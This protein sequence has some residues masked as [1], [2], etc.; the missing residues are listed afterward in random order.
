MKTK[1]IRNIFVLALIL[2]AAFGCS[3]FE[4]GP[5]ISLRSVVKRIYGVYRIDY[6]S[7]NGTDLTDYW[8]QY[9]DLKFRFYYDEFDQIEN[10][11]SEGV[12]GEIDSCGTWK[13][14]YNGYPSWIEIN[15]EVTILLNTIIIDS[16][17]YPD[18][19][20]YP[21]VTYSPAD[22]YQFKFTITRLTN[23]E[24][25]MYYKDGNDDYEIHF[26]E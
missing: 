11:P 18:R 7:K 1:S 25:W 2:T 16:L 15:D 23:K 21:L 20:F 14:Y 4:D 5:K 6:F 8:N 3:K 9:Y 22:Q 19:Q 10:S 13:P 17:A 24:M 12:S 26:E